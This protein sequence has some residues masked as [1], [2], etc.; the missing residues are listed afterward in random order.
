MPRKTPLLFVA[1]ALALAPL[2]VRAA[3]SMFDGIPESAAL[4]VRL[5]AP[6]A[7]VKKAADFA[8]RIKPEYGQAV[9]G[10]VDGL[11]IV[12][13]NPAMTGVDRKS[14]WWLIGFGVAGAAPAVAFAVP[15]TDADAM[16]KALG[17][18]FKFASYE[19]W[20]IYTES[21]QVLSQFADRKSGKLKPV[22]AALDGRSRKLFDRAD[23]GA[24]VNVRELRKT[25][26]NEIDAAKEQAQAFIKQMGGIIAAGPAQGINVDSIVKLYGDLATGAF[27]LAEDADG[28]A[29]G[30]V[31]GEK[32]VDVEG[33]LVVS[34]GTATDKV[35]ERNPPSEMKALGRLPASK[36]AYFG[37]AGDLAAL[38]RWGMQFST[39]AY[40][41]DEKFK[42]QSAEML[43]AFENQKI[44]GVYGSLS[45][46]NAN[47]G[48]LMLSAVAD[49]EAPE[50][51]TAAMVQLARSMNEMK[52]GPVTQKVS[53]TPAA[54]KIGSHS[55]DLFA[56]KQDVD[57]AQDPGGLVSMIYKTLYGP[58][59][60]VYRTTTIPGAVL[61]SMA[62]GKV[63]ME[64]L[65]KSEESG[66][67][68]SGEAAWSFARSQ[69]PAKVNL[70][71]MADI[72]KL[73]TEVLRILAD[74]KFPIDEA[75]VAQLQ[76]ELVPSYLGGS[77]AIEP[78][79]VAL[80][81]AIPLDQAKGIARLV[82]FATTKL[83]NRAAP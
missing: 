68:A 52:I 55:V 15:A 2:T 72:P 34:A 28:L 8:G 3:D 30:I 61:F 62:K 24:Y 14:D 77:A 27:Q 75:A 13:S 1:A 43:K 23:L 49:V 64:E 11:G 66:S 57:P 80:K 37:A 63:Q 47:E 40:Q 35:L 9:A 36:V 78:Q 71:G 58:N 54:E 50:K 51:F 83:F 69:L 46:G 29:A 20:V 25:Y 26:R 33:L 65:V 16:K 17:D 82:E 41:G 32:Q 10:A 5:K 6:E 39:S 48:V 73:A 31:L 81:L 22:S 4:L 56:I 70:I 19:K 53:V 45:L 7:T 12:I 59:G 67:G 21:E 76:H 74:L 79:A 38:V 44:S 18:R 42:K 60:M